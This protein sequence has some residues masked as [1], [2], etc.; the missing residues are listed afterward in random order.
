MT[1]EEFDAISTEKQ[2]AWDAGG[3]STLDGVCAIVSYP[4]GPEYRQHCWYPNGNQGS[5]SGG[6]D[7]PAV[8]Q[9]ISCQENWARIC[10]APVAEGGEQGNPACPGAA[11]APAPAPPPEEPAPAPPPAP[12]VPEGPVPISID[13][14]AFTPGGG[15]PTVPMPPAFQPTPRAPAAPPTVVECP[16]GPVPLRHW[17][18]ACAQSKEPMPEEASVGGDLLGI[19]VAGAAIAAG[20]LALLL[21]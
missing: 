1:P 20:A 12:P 19:G 11:P 7:S 3:R 5:S 18:N 21:K 15:I 6:A 10:Q 17:V 2:A 13:V 8:A 14:Q 16:D 4:S 9:M